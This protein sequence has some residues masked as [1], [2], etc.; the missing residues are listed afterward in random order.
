[1]WMEMQKLWRGEL[2]LPLAFWSYAIVYGSLGNLITTMA[3]LGALVAE[4][5]NALVL[6]IFLLPLP[7]NVTAVIGVWRSAARYRGPEHWANLARAAVVIWAVIA[8]VV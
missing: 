8:T 2:P 6:A 7:Y 5:H 3:A 4:L 1:M